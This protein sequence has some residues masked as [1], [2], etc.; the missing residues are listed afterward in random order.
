MVPSGATEH[1]PSKISGGERFVRSLVNGL[2]SSSAWKSS[3]F[4]WTYD[5]W[6]GWYD[7]VRPPTVDGY[8]YGFRSPALL[9]SP[10]AKKGYVDHTTLDFTSEL[11]FIENNWGVAPLAKRDR[12][13]ND[14]TAA[15]DFKAAPRDAAILPR[16]RAAA[17]L[18]IGSI[19]AVYPAYGVAVLLVSVLV[20]FATVGRRRFFTGVAR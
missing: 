11:K 3:A 9:V 16:T 6:G 14:I 19:S 1:P 15:F 17:P 13:A 10:Y 20:A 5:S 4:M 2:M 8:G 7:H 12:S 18:P